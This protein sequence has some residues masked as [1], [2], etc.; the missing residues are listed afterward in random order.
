MADDD[1]ETFDDILGDTSVPERSN[2]LSSDN[3]G[4]Q[5]KDQ[6]TKGKRKPRAK[7][8]EVVADIVEVRIKEF[9]LNTIPPLK[10]SDK[11]GVKIVVIGKAGTGKST[12]IQAL[13]ASKAHIAPVIQVFNGT[14]ESNGTYS[15]RV[16]PVFVHDKLDLNALIE[17]KKRQTLA[18]RNIPENPWAIQVIDDCTDDPKNLRHPLIQAYYKNGRHWH[19][20]HILSLQYSLDI[21]PNIRSN[22]DYVFI[23]RESS[24]KNRKKLF[25]NYCPDCIE[26]Q[27]EFNALMDALTEDYGALVIVNRGSSNKMED[28]VFY[29]KADPNAVAPNWKFGHH[30]CWEFN[31]ERFDPDYVDAIV[32]D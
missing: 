19:M 18:A 13:L 27:E 32:K 9:D 12:V 5:N 31:Q 26:T 14:E 11:S 16:P 15:A 7:K 2:K 17:F 29:F 4:N 3:D 10:P 8:A 22:I 20:I 23:M 28:C 1:Y 25:E 21:M 24:K 30:T 6:S